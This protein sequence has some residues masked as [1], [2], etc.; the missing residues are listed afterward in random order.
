MPDDISVA[1][2]SIET[3][4]TESATDLSKHR[5]AG[6]DRADAPGATK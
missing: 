3:S 5:M 4:G 1:F 6:A 2:V